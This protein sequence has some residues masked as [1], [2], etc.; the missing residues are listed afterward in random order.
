MTAARDLP[1]VTVD[2]LIAMDREALLAAHGDWISLTPVRPQLGVHWD[3]SAKRYLDGQGVYW[4]VLPEPTSISLAL[5]SALI[6]LP[7]EARQPQS[8]LA[9]LLST[10]GC[11]AMLLGFAY[12]V[13][14]IL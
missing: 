2:Q 1:P 10:W 12:L 14:K 8:R 3:G 7:V 9:S 6:G 13:G 4:E 5:Q 11:C